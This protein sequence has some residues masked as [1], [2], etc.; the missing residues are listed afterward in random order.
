MLISIVLPEY[1][2]VRKQKRHFLLPY[3]FSPFSFLLLPF[4]ILHP[5]HIHA[6]Y[7]PKRER[8]NEQERWHGV[9]HPLYQRWR[10]L[11]ISLIIER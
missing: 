10:S 3:H 7:H 8:K 9:D 2:Q 6:N 1:S 11:L 5:I 4:L